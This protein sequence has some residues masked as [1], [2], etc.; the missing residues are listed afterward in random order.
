MNTRP[1]ILLL[2]FLLFYGKLSSE[3]LLP[4]E[5]ECVRISDKLASVLYEECIDRDLQISDG[6]SVKDAPLL[7]KEYPPLPERRQPKGRVLL[8]GGIHGDEFV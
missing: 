5:Q 4:V 6:Y 2:P 8:I 3:P 7:I 1:F